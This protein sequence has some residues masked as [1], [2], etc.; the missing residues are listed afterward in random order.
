MQKTNEKTKNIET[1]SSLKF[2]QALKY[3]GIRPFNAYLKIAVKEV[4]KR[5]VK[6]F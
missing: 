6:Y 1:N 3:E 2:M 4:S 5:E